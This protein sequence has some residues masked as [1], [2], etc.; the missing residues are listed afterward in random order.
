MDGASLHIEPSREGE[1]EQVQMKNH[2]DEMTLV[3]KQV[4]LGQY[5]AV[6]CPLPLTTLDVTHSFPLSSNGIYG[7]DILAVAVERPK[8]G[9]GE[10]EGKG[11]SRSALHR[12]RISAVEPTRLNNT[13]VQ[14]VSTDIFNHFVLPNPA[15]PRARRALWPERPCSALH[16]NFCVPW[17]VKRYEHE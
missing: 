2:R 8:G 4:C 10:S 16:E 9:G 3:E 17:A 11:Q 6:F 1:E 12:F 7:D 14:A 13:R 15:L 5:R